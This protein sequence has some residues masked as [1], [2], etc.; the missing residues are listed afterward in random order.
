MAEVSNMSLEIDSYLPK[1]PLLTAAETARLLGYP[2]TGALAKARQAGRLPIEMF[3]VPGRR[4][5][6]AA[7][8][9][10]RAWLQAVVSGDSATPTPVK[11]KQ[12]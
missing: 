5:W 2:T 3:Q 1:A 9:K 8:P 4:G 12:P 7:T 10:V 11:E 6:F